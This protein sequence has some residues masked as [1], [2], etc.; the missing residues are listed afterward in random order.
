MRG[1]V[2]LLGRI[3]RLA[4]LAAPAV[5]VSLCVGAQSDPAVTITV[6]PAIASGPMI[7]DALKIVLGLT[8]IALIP[9]ALIAMTSFTRMIIVLA[10]LRQAFGMQ[11]TPPNMILLSL[12]LFLTVFTMAPVF[13]NAYEQ[14]IE[15]L[16]ENRASIDVAVTASVAPFRDFMIRQTRESDLALILDVAGAQVP[17]SAANLQTIHLVPAFLLSELKTAFQIGFIIF[18]PFLLLDIVV[19]SI[20]M[21]LGM[22]M[23]PPTII[24]LPLKVMMFVLIDGWAL[25]VRALLGSFA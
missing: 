22:L 10:M 9:A 11:E 21:S 24:S 3:V 1:E 20:L 13:S 16:L 18:L 19:A 5:L 14:G 23:V 15:P 2:D 6:D 25:C 7:A 17:D 8:A 4:A 12:A